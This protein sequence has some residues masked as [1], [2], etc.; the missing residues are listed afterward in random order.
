LFENQMFID[1][2][3]VIVKCFDSSI[4]NKHY[5][6]YSFC[7]G[8]LQEGETYGQAERIASAVGTGEGIRAA[9]A[10]FAADSPGNLYPQSIPNYDA[11]VTI[12]NANGG[13]LPRTEAE[14]SIS[15]GAYEMEKGTGDYRMLLHVNDVPTDKKGH[16]IILA[17]A[18]V[19]K[20]PA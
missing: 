7:H 8:L 2:V 11:L 18:G 1:T 10:S 19:E 4:I 5:A 12:A 13:T 15:F 3:G 20:C 16:C 17:P 9:L 6:V 14:A